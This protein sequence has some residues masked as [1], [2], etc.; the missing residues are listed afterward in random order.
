MPMCCDGEKIAQR[1]WDE[2]G[3]LL[4]GEEF[5]EGGLA[6]VQA[7]LEGGHELHT[8]GDEAVWALCRPE[9]NSRREQ[10]VEE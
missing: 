10:C 4:F 2:R 8:D 6:F 9:R 3:E 5:K 1:W 7:P